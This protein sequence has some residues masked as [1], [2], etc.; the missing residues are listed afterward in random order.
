MNIG[1]I[2]S[3]SSSETELIARIQKGE[4]FIEENKNFE[5]GITYYLS[6]QYTGKSQNKTKILLSKNQK[7]Q[8]PI[9]VLPILEKSKTYDFIFT[10]DR[11]YN[12]IIFDNVTLEASNLVLIKLNN[13]LGNVKIIKDLG[14]Q[15]EPGLR[16]SINGDDFTLGKSGFFYLSDLDITKV[17]FHKRTKEEF[18]IMTYQY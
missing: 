3:Q 10:P 4:I 7:E 18:F 14:I 15:G 9:R 2:T 11:D 13:I 1:Q 17:C 6:F 8:M 5:K 16:F 12:S